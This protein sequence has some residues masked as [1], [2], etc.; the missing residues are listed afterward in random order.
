MFKTF[1]SGSHTVLVTLGTLKY[2]HNGRLKDMRSALINKLEAFDKFLNLRFTVPQQKCV[3]GVFSF[4]EWSNIKISGWPFATKS[5]HE[6]LAEAI[7]I[8]GAVA[9]IDKSTF[10]EHVIN[11]CCGSLGR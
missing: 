8:G 9:L 4:D 7:I 1:V 10:S 5:T 3:E 2:C 11:Y 6:T